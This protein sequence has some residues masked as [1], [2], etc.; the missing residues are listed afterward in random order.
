VNK[1]EPATIRQYIIENFLFGDTSKVFTDQDSLLQKGIVD[2]TGILE[3]INYLQEAFGIM[4][5]D[6]EILPENLDSV[7]NLAHFIEK[8]RTA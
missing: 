2:S 6:D 1:P 8:K 4:V 5:T 3:L 7:Q